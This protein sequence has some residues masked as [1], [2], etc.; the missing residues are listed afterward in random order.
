MAACNAPLLI[1]AER[2]VCPAEMI[3]IPGFLCTSKELIRENVDELKYCF[4]IVSVAKMFCDQCEA[5]LEAGSEATAG[6]I[7]ERIERPREPV[8]GPMLAWPRRRVGAGG[9]AGR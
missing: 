7:E 4:G 5:S 3:M 9:G 8:L 6:D 2:F 1:L